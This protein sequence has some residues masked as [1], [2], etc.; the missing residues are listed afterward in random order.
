MKQGEK[1]VKNTFYKIKDR[2]KSF[3]H[4]NSHSI[5]QSNPENLEASSDNIASSSWNPR[6]IFIYTRD[7][8]EI[9]PNSILTQAFN[10]QNP[11]EQLESDSLAAYRQFHEDTQLAIQLSEL[12]LISKNQDQYLSNNEKKLI[13]KQYKVTPPDEFLDALTYNLMD[14]PVKFICNNKISDAIYDKKTADKIMGEPNPLNPFTREPIDN[15]IPDIK[16]KERIDLW[17]KQNTTT[18]NSKNLK[19]TPTYKENL[20]SRLN[21]HALQKMQ[22]GQDEENCSFKLKFKK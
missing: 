6:Q 7:S 13:K 3:R 18:L 12:D 9:Q 1:K 8:D 10:N 14:T 4:K 19:S 21:R 20:F 11:S 15:Y 16:L 22:P 5:K 2:L 17:M